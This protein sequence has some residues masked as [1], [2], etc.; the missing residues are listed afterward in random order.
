M[1]I[2]VARLL[3]VFLLFSTGC[4]EP[5]RTVAPMAQRPALAFDETGIVVIESDS[6]NGFIYGFFLR[7]PTFTTDSIV[8]ADSYDGRRRG[9]P[10]SRITRIVTR[11]QYVID[12]FVSLHPGS[13]P[14]PI[15]SHYRNC[16][17]CLEIR[18]RK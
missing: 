18:V 12:K 3:T 4:V 17:G 5:Y 9:A 15:S 11:E 8:G 10:L 7:Y 6:G 16:I 1:G 14:V 2:R 13:A